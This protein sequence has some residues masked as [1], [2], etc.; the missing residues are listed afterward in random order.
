MPSDQIDPFLF[1]CTALTVFVSIYYL[2]AGAAM[3]RAA[4]QALR[5]EDA[6][7]RFLR[8]YL[9]YQIVS[10]RIR[11]FAAELL[12]I[13]AWLTILALLWWVQLAP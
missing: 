5:G 11:P 9:L 8:T 3:L 4:S 1:F 6:E 2:L 12:Q 10:V 13:V 7:R